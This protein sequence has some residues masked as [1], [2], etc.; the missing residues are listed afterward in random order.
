MKNFNPRPPR[1][2]RRSSCDAK[3]RIRHISIHALREEDGLFAVILIPAVCDISIHALREEDGRTCNKP[4]IS[5]RDF[6]PRPP[7]GG[8]PCNHKNKRLR[9]HFNPRPPRGGRR[10]KATA[11]PDFQRD[12]NPRPPRGGRRSA[13][14]P[15]LPPSTFQSTPSARRTAKETNVDKAKLKISIH[16]LREEDGFASEPEDSLLRFQSTPSAR[17]TAAAYFSIFASF[18][19]QSTPSARRTATHW[20]PLP[21]PPKISIHALREEDGFAGMGTVRM[22]FI[23]IHALREEDGPVLLS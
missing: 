14:K 11:N 7:R 12:F 17:R 10:S 9:K 5:F 21:Q 1:G 15:L 23:S 20:M 6:N 2:G 8:R 16:A 22:G 18:K 3:P 13:V 19:F 4:R